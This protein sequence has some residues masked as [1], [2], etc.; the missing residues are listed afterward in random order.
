VKEVIGLSA[1]GMHGLV[2]VSGPRELKSSCKQIA[3]KCKVDFFAEE[4]EL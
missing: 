2:Y 4:F 3:H 1:Y